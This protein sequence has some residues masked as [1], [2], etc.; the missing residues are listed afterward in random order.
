MRKQENEKRIVERRGELIAKKVIVR[1]VRRWR[2]RRAVLALVASKKV[3]DPAM[4][5]KISSVLRA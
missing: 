3:K 1:F 2:F 5:K 4:M